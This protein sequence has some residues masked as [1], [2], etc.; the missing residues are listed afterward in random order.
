[1]FFWADFGKNIGRGHVALPPKVSAKSIP[2]EAW[3]LVQ[4]HLDIARSLIP[5]SERRYL[6][7]KYGFDVENSLV[8]SLDWI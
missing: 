3:S 5:A 1:M 6:K 8:L 2:P 4:R 7:E